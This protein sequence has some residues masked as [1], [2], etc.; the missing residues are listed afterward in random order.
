MNVKEI[1][2]QNLKGLIKKYGTQEA[3]EEASGA[4]ANYA[5]QVLNGTRDMGDR[6]AETIEDGLKL[7]KGW[8]DKLQ[9][10][11]EISEAAD[12]KM[13]AQRKKLQN[14][15]HL[16]TLFRQMEAWAKARK[17]GDL[18][19]NQRAI[20]LQRALEADEPE[21]A[22]NYEPHFNNVI[23]MSKHWKTR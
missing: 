17:L 10:D 5:S 3:F 15:K 7:S 12:A 22:P 14:T 9:D 2:R 6:Y 1:R 8:M 4:S 19:P 23:E 21:E 18:S 13:V 16:T 11:S 20:L